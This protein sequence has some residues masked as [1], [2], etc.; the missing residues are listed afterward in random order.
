MFSALNLSVT[1]SG[2]EVLHGIDLALAPGE[3]T[4]FVG[5]NGAGK[6]TLLKRFTGE[7][8]TGQG[9]VLFDGTP[10]AHWPRRE[11]ARRRAVLSQSQHV[12]FPFTVFEVVSL[13][14]SAAESVSA[15]GRRKIV[16]ASLAAVDLPDAG[17]RLFLQL[18]GGEQQRVQFARVLSQLGGP[19]ADTGAPAK[20][21]FLDEPTASLDVAHQLA[22]LDV[23]R[24]HVRVG[25]GALAILHDLNLASLYAD[26][27]VVLADGRIRAS[28]APADV[29]TE[30]L[31]RSVFGERVRILEDRRSGYRFVLPEPAQPGMRHA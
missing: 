1:L 15:E 11:L 31:L 12:G 13:G 22:T 19:A 26:R 9:E 16:Q 17:R 30:P 10:L 6:S 20:W 21:L 14:L 3:L 5:P 24:R 8:R 23:A 2:R 27:L 4:V 18:S 28:G 25:G 7:L 29:L